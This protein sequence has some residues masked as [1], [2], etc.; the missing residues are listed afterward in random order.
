MLNAISYTDLRG[1]KME[2][3]EIKQ[4]SKED[5]T[6]YTIPES[7]KLLNTSVPTIY[8]MINL[9]ELKTVRIG[10]KTQRIKAIEVN[11]LLEFY[12]RTVT[13]LETSKILSIS[14]QSVHRMIKDGT[15]TVEQMDG[16]P[17]RVPLESI[18]DV[19]GEYSF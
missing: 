19:A 8:R 12:N 13:I 6:F 4:N 1:Y 14:I 10:K 11:T 5:L 9:G 18:R 2:M 16:K 17:M 7:A 3:S 15:L